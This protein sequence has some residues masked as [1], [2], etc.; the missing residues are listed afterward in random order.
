MTKNEA[1]FA[2]IADRLR[3]EPLPEIPIKHEQ[4]ELATLLARMD[5]PNL[6]AIGQGEL[7]RHAAEE[8][9]TCD[10]ASSKH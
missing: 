2:A 10:K 5:D 8:A 6:R 1:Y 9:A 7:A 3:N 4:V